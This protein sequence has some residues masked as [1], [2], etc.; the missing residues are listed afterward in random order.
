MKRKIKLLFSIL[1]IYAVCCSFLQ[2]KGISSCHAGQSLILTGVVTSQKTGA[3]ITRGVVIINNGEPVEAVISGNAEYRIYLM[4]GDNFVVFKKA[5]Y[6]DTTIEVNFKNILNHEYIKFKNIALAPVEKSFRISGTVKDRVTTET[7][8]K[9]EL[10]INRQILIT[11]NEGYF[12]CMENYN[13]FEISAAA[14]GYFPYKAK[15]KKEK[16]ESGPLTVM[17]E[18]HTIHSVIRG[19]V[20]ERSTHEPVRAALVDIAGMRVL[21]DEEG[22]FEFRVPRS[23]KQ[24]LRCDAEGY[25]K[26][27]QSVKLKPGNNIISVFLSKKNNRVKSG[28]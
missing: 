9:A 4:P 3:K 10:R 16:A 15:M 2:E 26:I 28:K 7:I 22:N 1:L 18:R 24:L 8:K 25:E 21:S 12:E 14:D 27:F 6:Y 23:G 17:L 11:D 13:D 20:A 5:G 19:T